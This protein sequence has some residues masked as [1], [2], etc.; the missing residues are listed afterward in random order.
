MT[1]QNAAGSPPCSPSIPVEVAAKIA[2][3]IVQRALSGGEFRN[4]EG[5]VR[6]TEVDRLFETEMMASSNGEM[7]WDGQLQPAYERKLRLIES[8]FRAWPEP[9]AS[10]ACSILANNCLPS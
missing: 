7:I 10:E 3:N 9:A 2:R 1:R 4:E 8:Q 6:W 5:Y